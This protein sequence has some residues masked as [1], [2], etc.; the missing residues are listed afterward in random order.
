MSE[1]LVLIV[2]TV[3]LIGMYVF[4]TEKFNG[5][6]K[7][8]LIKSLP[9]T[10][11]RFRQICTNKL[12]RDADELM[13]YRI[14]VERGYPDIYDRTSPEYNRHYVNNMMLPISHQFLSSPETY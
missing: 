12:L 4:I 5:S 11:T 13:F 9:H 10:L 6:L 3:L 7:S 2:L 8:H 1:I 14:D